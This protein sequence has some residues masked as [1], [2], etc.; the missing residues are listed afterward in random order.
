VTTTATPSAR[1]LPR[2]PSRR[3]LPVVAPPGRPAASA[4]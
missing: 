3:H 1:A 2:V 4:A